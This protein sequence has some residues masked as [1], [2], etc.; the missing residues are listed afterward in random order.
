VRPQRPLIAR[1]LPTAVAGGIVATAL[2][3]SALLAPAQAATG[4]LAAAAR[5]V[6][7]ARPATVAAGAP[8][9]VSAAGADLVNTATGR[10]LWSRGL[11]IGR[12]IASITKV[13]TALVVIRAGGLTR[14]I[15]ISQAVVTYVKEHDGS[16]AGL[17]AGDVLTAHQ[18]LEGLLLPSGN[19]A[20]FALA[21]AY[22]PGWRAFVRKMNA[23]ARRLGMQHTHFANFDGLPWPTEYTTYSTPRDLIILGRAAMQLAA[24]RDIVGQ[25]THYLAATP[26]H[27]A[28]FWQNTNRLLGSYAGAFGIKT[29][30][31]HGAGYSLL[32]EA[33]RHGH[34][35][36]GVVLD[37]SGTDPTAPFTAARRLLNWGFAVLAA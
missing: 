4:Q 37:S 19:D 33:Q 12:P 17:H 1:S 2:A 13:M 5:P 25:R 6:A 34:T 32:F 18:L 36:I 27:H 24:F 29:G 10:R 15:R 21:G 30:F 14:K 3:C 8:V 16:S 9:G 28:Y 31:T 7:I 26:Q 22:G 23:A 20:A 11:N 35:L